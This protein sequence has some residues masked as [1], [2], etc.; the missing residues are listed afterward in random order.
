MVGESGSGKTTI[1]RML[2]RLVEPTSGSIGF[3]GRDILALSGRPL[4]QLRAG[5]QFVFQDPWSSLNPRL[6]IRSLIEEPLRI[7]TALSAAGRRT[8]LEALVQRVHLKADLLD[9]FP[10]QLS[11]GQLQRV[12]IARALATE[13]RLLILDEPTSALDLSVRASIIELL[14]EIQDTSGMGMVFISHDLATVRSISKRVMVLY[15]GT[16]IEEGPTED[17]FERPRHPY[18]QA[19]MTAHLPPDPAIPV[20]PQR[21]TGDPPSPSAVPEGCVFATRCPIAI[22]QCSMQNPQLLPVANENRRVALQKAA[23]LRL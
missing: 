8:R 17:V 6:S 15:R 10:G 12:C 9:R 4:R 16:I 23:C 13:P 19:L 7:H 3:E 1:G 5:L 22:E 18:T 14:Q 21:L 2:M 20:H 11:G